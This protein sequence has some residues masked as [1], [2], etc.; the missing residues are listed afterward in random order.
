[1]SAQPQCAGCPPRAGTP[2]PAPAPPRAKIGST[3]LERALFVDTGAWL[4][5][6]EANDRHHADVKRLLRLAAAESRPL[7]TTNLNIS[8]LQKFLLFAHNDPR[9]A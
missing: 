9:R 6:V 5:T 8:E 2:A 1:M 3:I 4:A 7:V